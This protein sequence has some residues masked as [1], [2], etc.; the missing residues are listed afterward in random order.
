M[1]ARERFRA[2][3]FAL[4]AAAGAPSGAWRAEQPQ[5]MEAWSTMAELQVA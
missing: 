5:R 4:Q 1:G 2:D 3:Y